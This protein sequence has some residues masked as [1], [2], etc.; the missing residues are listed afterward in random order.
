M[1][2]AAIPSYFYVLA[3]VEH[4]GKYLFVQERK[5]GQAWYLPAGGVEPGETLEQALARE[6]L[7]EAGVRVAPTRL[8]AVEPYWFRGE[9]GLASKWR[10]VFLARPVGET[11]PKSLPDRHTLGA[12]WLERRELGGYRWR[13]PEVVRWIDVVDVAHAD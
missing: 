11:T 7:E 4:Q 10:F 12:R 8:L 2:R 6:T 13:D 9:T 1:G 5:Y 3:V